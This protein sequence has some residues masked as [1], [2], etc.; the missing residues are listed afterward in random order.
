[1][2]QYTG[3]A[4]AS[5]DPKTRRS[6]GARLVE[7]LRMTIASSACAARS[8]VVEEIRTDVGL[9]MATRRASNEILRVG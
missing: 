8:P 9:S 7:T 6:I 5:S 4:G 1:M 2:R 3:C